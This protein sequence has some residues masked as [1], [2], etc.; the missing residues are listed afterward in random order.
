MNLRD[1]PAIA[2]CETDSAKV[3]AAVIAG[4]EQ[5][6]GVSLFPGDPVRLFLEGLAYLIAQQNYVIDY[7]GKQNLLSHADGGFLEHI[8]ALLN[9]SRLGSG[10]AVTSLT[11][12]LGEPLTWAVVI[13]Q[14]TRA[15][16]DGAVYFATD[17]E[18]SIPPGEM[19]VTVPATCTE[20]GAAH[21]GLLAGQINRLVD[22]IAYVATVANSV[23]TLGGTDLESD[24]RLRSRIQLAPERLSTCGPYGAYRY[25][26]LSVAP[27]ILDVAV[28]SPEPGSVHLAPLMVG[29]ELP[30]PEILAKIFEA[31]SSKDRR[32]MTDTVNVTTPAKMEYSI[33]G[34]YWIR[35]S[36]ANRGGQIQAAAAAVLDGFQLW[37]RSKLG[38][39]IL[40]SELTA[41]I[42][43]IE[44]VQR[45][46]LTEPVYQA[47]D[48]WQVATC[49][50]A[51]LTYGGLSDD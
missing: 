25:W 13:P 29:G 38:R 44:G 26:A 14:G 17:A 47:L 20:A 31:I 22:R 39:D 45:V 12:T 41:R 23:I 34:T 21:N 27:D 42:Q 6:A 4:Y 11:F 28:W 24:E 2:F 40:P 33:S 7:T 49:S 37:Q 19:S 50:A 5:I 8:G 10:Y 35:T 36:Y 3:E 51:S 18:A 9:T 46:E 43:A 32:P 16:P 48:P 30:G 1:L 15:T